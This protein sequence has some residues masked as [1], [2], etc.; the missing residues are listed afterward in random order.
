MNTIITSNSRSLRRA[1][2]TLLLGIAALRAMLR[3]AQAQLLYVGQLIRSAIQSRPATLSGLFTPNRMPAKSEMS[4]ELGM[5][6]MLL[7]RMASLLRVLSAGALL[8]CA[9]SII[10][11]PAV[12]N[13]I[14]VSG[15]SLRIAER[16]VND[17]GYSTGERIQL[18]ADSVT[19][20]GTT[21]GGTTATAQTTNLSTGV[22]T[23]PIVLPF[24]PVSTLPNQFNTTFPYES[25]LTSPWTVTFTNVSTV[26]ASTTVIT[27]SLVGVAPA[28]FANNVTVG[29]GLNPTFT[30]SYP[31]SVDGV[32]VEIFEKGIH[33]DPSTGLLET[34]GSDLVFAH[35]LAGAMNSY[36]LLPVSD[37]GFTLTPGTN[38]V[39]GLR[40]S[41]LRSLATPLMLTNA[42]TA[43]ESVAYFDFT[44]TSAGIQ[45]QVYLPTIGPNGVYNFNL[46]VQPNTTYYIDPTVATGF[47]YTIG[48]G[49]PRFATV[50]LPTLQGSEPYTITWNKGR[51][52]K[53]VLGGDVFNFLLTDPLGVSTFTVTG[54][55]PA[56]GLDPASGTEFVT[57][58]TFVS[59]GSFTGTMT[60]ITTGPDVYITNEGSKTVSVINPPVIPSLRPSG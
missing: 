25:Y 49:N 27:P 21:T 36:T 9:S 42:N 60:P 18:S 30:W 7:N 47:I 51:D 50:V 52:A 11:Y 58:L 4:V 33:I 32:T 53:R 28:P 24:D 10:V 59:G 13:P 22:L 46:T 39:V 44:P 41:I 8:G 5:I 19:P 31:S 55:D 15:V 16:S 12:A 20:N 29:S 43:S 3:N 38:Y 54:I 40:G 2:C 14:V 34:G 45:P 57:G 23:T 35:S 48:A 26:P 37:G 1:L 17:L 56:D 6:P